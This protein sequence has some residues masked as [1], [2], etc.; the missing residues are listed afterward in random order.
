MYVTPVASS[1]TMWLVLMV[2]ILGVT[3]TPM[4]MVTRGT[5]EATSNSSGVCRQAVTSAKPCGGVV[6]HTTANACTGEEGLGGVGVFVGRLEALLV[7]S[8]EAELV[9]LLASRS[10]MAGRSPQQPQLVGMDVELFPT[11]KTSGFSSLWLTL[12]HRVPW[13]HW[14]KGLWTLILLLLGK[15]HS[16]EHLLIGEG[17]VP[18]HLLPQLLHALC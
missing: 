3:T 11:P 16:P 4:D 2:K 18:L 14:W 1:L 9:P 17:E 6:G 12:V 8:R 7:Q 10:W 13:G 15:S 5:S